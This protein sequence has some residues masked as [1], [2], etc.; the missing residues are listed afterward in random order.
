MPSLCVVAPEAYPTLAGLNIGVA[1]GAELQQVLIARG[2][3]KMGWDVT[4]VAGDYGQER[5]VEFD[6][7]RALRTYRVG[8]GNRKARYVPDT[9]AMFAAMREANADAYLQRCVFHHTDRVA[10][11]CRMHRKPFIFSAGADANGLAPDQIAGLRALHRV[12]YPWAIKGAASILCQSRVQ[13]EAFRAN[14]GREATILPNIVPDADIAAARVHT[15]AARTALWVG[16]FS[17]GKRPLAFLDLAEHFPDIAFR[18]AGMEMDSDVTQQARQRAAAMDNV[19]WLGFLDAES[20]RAEFRS[21]D[22]FVSTAA[23]EGFPNTFLQSMSAGVPVLS[24]A[25]D[26]DGVLAR[27]GMGTVCGDDPILLASE[28]GR[29]SREPELRTTM[30]SAGIGYVCA[31]HASSAVIPRYAEA[32]RSAIA[33]YPG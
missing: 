28:L 27:F 16:S 3:A 2:L 23:L 8:E 19:T 7:V 15:G 1:G 30:G 29:L 20:V 21:A 6:G 5:I 24:L 4:F 18:I 10:L 31:N 25:V 32:I 12:S 11:F 14:Y 26:P 17:R 9:L 33:A 22:V 13:A